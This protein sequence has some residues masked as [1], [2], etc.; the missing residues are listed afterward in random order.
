VLASV[1]SYSK[2]T[3]ENL[4]LHDC[5]LQEPGISAIA[6]ALVYVKFIKSLDVSK[7][8]I[9]EV[10]AKKLPVA[11][12]SHFM[13]S[14]LNLSNCFSENTST[15]L[16]VL[17]A[18]KVKTT[19]INLNLES[20]HVTHNIAIVL[21]VVISNN[22][23]LKY[24]NLSNCSISESAFMVI[25]SSLNVVSLQC[26]IL[27]ANNINAGI[28]KHLSTV[29]CNNCILNYLD[30]CNTTLEVI[31]LFTNLII[32]NV[33]FLHHLDLSCNVIKDQEAKV[34]S[35]ALANMSEMQHINLAKCCLSEVGTSIILSSLRDITSLHYMNL[36][37]CHINYESSTLVATIISNNF[38]LSHLLL[39]KCKLSGKGLMNISNVL[40]HVSSLQNLSFSSND[41]ANEAALHLSEAIKANLPLQSL[42]ICECNFEEIG[43]LHITQALQ[44]ISSLQHLDLSGNEITDTAAESLAL[45]LSQ[46]VGVQHLD[47][48]YCTWEYSGQMKINEVLHKLSILKHY[49]I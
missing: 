12:N 13:L 37:S 28:A 32:G 39:T 25:L 27:S 11:I 45:A 31:P 14:Y 26:L 16:L 47:L 23:E 15:F 21:A 4:N 19:L 5:D 6:K 30:L 9:P 7:N 42:S 3:L 8:K 48:S 2:N 18:L 22:S 41:F 36:E 17:E 40:K 29:V 46:N 43:L 34:L 20:N 10:A 1:L 49:D 38:L 44:T 24:L 33:N 35:R